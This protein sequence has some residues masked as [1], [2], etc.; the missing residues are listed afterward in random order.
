LLIHFSDLLRYGLL[1]ARQGL[2][3]QDLGLY[4]NIDRTNASRGMDAWIESMYSW[5]SSQIALPSLPV[6]ISHSS[7][8]LRAD[9]PN[10]LFFFVDG[11][12][13][14]I[15]TPGD[16]KCRRN[17]YNNKHGYCSWSFF[18]LVDPFG[19]IAYVSEVSLGAEHDSTQW[20]SSDCVAKLQ[21]KYSPAKNWTYC[22]GGDKAYPNINLPDKWHLYVTM[23]ATEPN[24]VREVI[25]CYRE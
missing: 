15:F 11:T 22:L 3:D 16:A 20:N 25:E 8:S 18:L 14:E 1:W 2:S 10:R 19:H 13:L 23:T 24:T 7:E 21:A 17:H 4:L 9:F 6:W 12:V 5:A